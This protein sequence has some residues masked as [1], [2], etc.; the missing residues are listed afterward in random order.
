M[1]PTIGEVN[2]D[3]QRS[4]SRMTRIVT[5]SIL[6]IVLGLLFVLSFTAPRPNQFWFQSAAYLIIAILEFATALFI[7]SAFADAI[8]LRNVRLMP[9]RGRHII[10][11][12]IFIILAVMTVLFGHR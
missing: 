1:N 6:A 9:S 7:D 12:L 3:I 8:G 4:T 5:Q 11:G 2:M 10:V